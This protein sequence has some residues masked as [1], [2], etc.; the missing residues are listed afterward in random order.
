MSTIE[1]QVL[2][3]LKDALSK[4][5]DVPTSVADSV[6][7]ELTQS[8]DPNA[9]KLADIYRAATGEDVA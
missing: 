5:P 3:D 9:E 7:A 1:A 8:H 2:S 4:L 6:I